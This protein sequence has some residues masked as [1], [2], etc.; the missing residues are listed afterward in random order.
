MSGNILDLLITSNP[1]IIDDINVSDGISDHDLI[2]F[3]I[4]ISPKYQ[5]K[6]PHKVYKY[7]QA[8]HDE[9]RTRVKLLSEHFFHRNPHKCSVDVNWNFLKHGLLG[10]LD[11]CVPNKLS[12]SKP[13]LPWITQEIKRAMRKR[14]RLHKSARS[15]KDQ[16]KWQKFRTF[17][18]NLTAKIK[19]SH[20]DYLTNIIGSSLK[21]EN[22]KPFWNYIKLMKTENTSIPI[23]KSGTKLCSSDFDK[24]EALNNQFKQA[25]TSETHPLPTLPKSPYLTIHDLIIDQLGVEK[26]LKSL[27]VNK[28]TGPDEISAKL[29]HLVAHEISR[30][31]TW[32]FQQS[33]DT[34]TIPL[35]WSKALVTP[36]FKKGPKSEPSNYRPVS[37]TSI[38]CKVLEHI[39]LSHMA[40]H[41]EANGI[42]SPLNHGFRQGLSCETQLITAINDWS[43]SLNNYK[44]VDLITLDFAKAFDKVPHQRLLSK[45][46]YYGIRNNVLAW[47]SAFLSD[48]K[49]VVSINGTHSREIEVTSGV[50]QGTVLGP[51]LFLI[52][53]NDIA[54]NIT[55]HMRLFADDSI[56]YREI[57]TPSDAIILQ[58][59]LN[60]LEEWANTWQMSFNTS[61]CTVMT[62]TNKRNPLPAIYSLNQCALSKVTKQDYLGVTISSKLQWSSHVSKIAKSA[63]TKLGLLRRTLHS[64]SKEVKITAYTSLVRPKLEYASSA[65]NPHTN[66][67]ITKIENIQRQAARFVYSDYKITSSPTLMLNQLKWQSLHDRRLISQATMFHK[68][69]NQQVHIPL[70]SN[71]KILRQDRCLRYFGHSQYTFPPPSVNAYQFSFYPSVIRVWNQLPTNITRAPTHQSFKSQYSSFLSNR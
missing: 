25:F 70:P 49:Q 38:T 7:H 40:K 68:I 18:N 58:Q 3:T 46:S 34:G 54:N 53:I 33:I 37:L 22:P 30:P 48:R 5:A 28:A 39:V 60:K 65:W 47:I 62:I 71:I 31:L 56:I 36:I 23:L 51:A 35:D 61:K 20:S 29:L 64:C 27:N 32:L 44:Q 11:K 67:D 21:S 14:D 57:N 8:D 4:N 59:D 55:S 17:R 45:L 63:S 15:S 69:I 13:H 2:T 10:I 19:R 1:N 42:L 16:N 50:P 52:Y 24:A 41:L 12:K 6:K 43:V 26:Q 66:R 9:I